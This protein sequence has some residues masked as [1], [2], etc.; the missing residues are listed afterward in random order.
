MQ[1]I[2]FFAFIISLIFLVEISVSPAQTLQDSSK[3]KHHAPTQVVDS[4]E[5]STL[6]NIFYKG[7][8]LGM[9]FLFCLYA[10]FEMRAMKKQNLMLQNQLIESYS[11]NFTALI[12]EYKQ[13]NNHLLKFLK[14][15]A[16]FLNS[17]K[18]ANL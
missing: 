14:I 4:S 18:D 16:N 7:G 2:K 10:Y 15:V 1:K 11:K 9:A 3:R 13:H 17:K 6:W 5:L 12:D 8:G